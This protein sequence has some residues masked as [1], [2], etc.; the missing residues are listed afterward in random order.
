MF[1]YSGHGVIFAEE[2][3]DQPLTH[4]VHK[5]AKLEVLTPIENMLRILANQPDVLVLSFLD[6]CRTAVTG[7]VIKGAKI[8]EPSP[9]K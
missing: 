5:D 7:T 6:C 2:Q 1:Y 8:P 9:T 3:G 4:M